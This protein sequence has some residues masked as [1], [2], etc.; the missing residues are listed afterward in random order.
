[1]VI[2][3]CIRWKLKD[4][5]QKEKRV[6]EDDMVGW[7]HRFN[8]QELGQ[9][10]G[11]SEGHGGL[12]CCNP[13]FAKSGTQLSDWTTTKAIHLIIQ[14]LPG[15]SIS[16]S[17]G[18]T[19]PQFPVWTSSGPESDLF[20]TLMLKKLLC[21]TNWIFALGSGLGFWSEV[22]S[23]SLQ[24]IRDSEIMILILTLSPA[25]TYS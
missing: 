3:I 12:A 19:R 10:L 20:T 8:G 22:V 14:P 16:W 13:W 1:M 18:T 6:T 5:K 25:P 11:D 24:A 7:H 15:R 17:L 9:T 4:W 21:V 2:P 23:Q